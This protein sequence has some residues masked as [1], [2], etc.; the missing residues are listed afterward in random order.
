MVQPCQ[1][2]VRTP[3]LPFSSIDRDTQYLVGVLWVK[4]GGNHGRQWQNPVIVIVIILNNNIRCINTGVADVCDNF[5]GLITCL[6]FLFII[7][8]NFRGLITCLT[9][10]NMQFRSILTI[11]GRNIVIVI[12]LSTIRVYIV[13]MSIV[14]MSSGIDVCISMISLGTNLAKKNWFSFMFV[15][16][17]RSTW[18]NNVILSFLGCLS[19]TCC[20]RLS[21]TPF[22]IPC[23]FVEELVCVSRKLFRA[24]VQPLDQNRSLPSLLKSSLW[25]TL[26]EIKFHMQKNIYS[27]V[28]P[29]WLNPTRYSFL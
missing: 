5:R 6:A 16:S 24:K 23:H 20:S 26:A 9:F 17:V 27:S 25:V 2:M 4:L 18:W 28:T 11:G 13:V 1:S 12:A 14:C 29:P 3:D 21:W 22:S 10:M 19:C 15:L 7:I 8:N